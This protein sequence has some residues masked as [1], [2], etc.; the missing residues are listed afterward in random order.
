MRALVLVKTSARAARKV[1]EAAKRVKGVKDAFLVFG[2]FDAAIL[3]EAGG[4]QDVTRIGMEINRLEGVK[5]T[6]TLPE[7]G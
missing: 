3:I 6:E 7:A 1:V 2:R 5:S 4:F